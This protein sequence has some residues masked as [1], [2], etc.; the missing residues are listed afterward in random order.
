MLVLSYGVTKS[1][2][3]L[4]FELLKGAL[5]SAGHP[6]DLL[7]DTA[8]EPGH[9]VNFIDAVTPQKIQALQAA[10]PEGRII[11]VKTHTRLTRSN[12]AML[13]AAARAGEIFVQTVARDPRDVC[14][15]MLDAGTQARAGN[16]GAFKEFRELADAERSCKNQYRNYFHWASVSK[17][18]RLTYDQIVTDPDAAVARMSDQI[19]IFANPAQARHHAFEKAFTQKNKAVPN[20][21]E[22]EMKPQ[23]AARIRKDLAAVWMRSLDRDAIAWFAMHRRKLLTSE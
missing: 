9:H 18:L 19:G 14:L 17:A 6:Q 16:L 8:V 11:A 10:I 4:A 3:T 5:E 2:S 15:S 13:D 21:W 22:T 7:P 23:D 20:R 1:G 12:F